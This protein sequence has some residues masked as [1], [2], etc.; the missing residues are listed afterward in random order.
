MTKTAPV[1]RVQWRYCEILW[2]VTHIPNAGREGNDVWIDVG[3][4]LIGVQAL[5]GYL[6]SKPDQTLHV[7]DQ[8]LSTGND[9]GKDI[10]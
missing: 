7:G 6:T 5:Q 4:K 9:I 1:L 10:A 3:N 8:F 2:Y